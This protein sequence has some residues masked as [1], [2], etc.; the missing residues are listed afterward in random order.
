MDIDQYSW[1]LRG[2][3][4]RSIVYRGGREEEE[5]KDRDVIGMTR[6][7]RRIEY[8]RIKGKVLGNVEG[9]KEKDE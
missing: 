8:K 4:R 9:G 6:Q 7:V 2:N 3:Y 5:E 1:R